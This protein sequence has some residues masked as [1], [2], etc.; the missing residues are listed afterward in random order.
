VRFALES[1]PNETLDAVRAK[2]R[3]LGRL[4]SRETALS[5]WKLVAN[6]WCSAWF[7]VN[8]RSVPASAFSTLADRIVAGAGGPPDTF[9]AE[10]LRLADEV[11]AARRFF[12]WELECPEVFFDP[13]GTR[14]VAPGFDAVLGNPPWDMVR[15]D[16]GSREVRR[17]TR[18]DVDQM[19][20]FTRRA[21]VYTARSSGHP[22]LYQLFTERAMA[23]VR[24]AGRIG[25]VLPSGLAIDHGS[26]QLRQR[27]LSECDVDTLVGFD[28]RAGLFPIHRSVRFLLLT[29]TA[30][31]PTRSIACRL[32][33]RDPSR[34]ESLA[35]NLREESAFFSV[36]LTPGLIQR[37][38][39]D[40][41]V[42]PELRTTRDLA[43]AERAATLF[44]PLGSE[45]G[46]G[47]RFGRELNATDDRGQFS[48]PGEGLPIVEGKHISP[49]RVHVESARQSISTRRARRLLDP[50]R[51][52]RPRLGYRDVAGSTNRLTL[53]AAVLPSGCVSTHTIFCLRTPLPPVSQHFL[54][55]LFNSFVVNYLVRMRVST[56]VTTATVERLPI[57]GF[58]ESPRRSRR[59]AALARRLVR[60]DDTTAFARLQ[61][62]VA[63]LYRL[64]C[65]EF[66]HV[67]DTFPLIPKKERD[68][69][70]QMYVGPESR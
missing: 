8:G 40:S 27:L 48:G 35:D 51:F 17:G 3:A 18:S 49:F 33:E 26:A 23:L 68:G 19:L 31:S 43:I 2:E 6:V 66:A 22:N 41:L 16:A 52:E 30:G 55:G 7:S 61:V 9:T 10:C 67:L 39:G 12:H 1:I 11:A 57:P 13:D 58:E 42:I 62:L 45:Q 70:L 50:A 21:G 63:E 5:R 29:A 69:I 59:I 14:P 25:L 38:S 4:N 36:R 24:P 28:N 54:C 53:I 47:A 60:R 15:A 46:W 32:G 44:P 65:S 20:A 37:L 34:L 56:H 64:S